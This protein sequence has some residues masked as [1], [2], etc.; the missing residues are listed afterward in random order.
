MAVMV[1]V[2]CATKLLA[3][4]RPCNFPGQNLAC[5]DRPPR[6]HEEHKFSSL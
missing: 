6:R 1:T 4:A 2:K 5:R 3:R